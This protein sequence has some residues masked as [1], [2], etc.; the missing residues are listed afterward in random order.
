MA[1]LQY[2]GARYV[3][4]LFDN[5][6]DHSITW[7]AGVSY[8][9]LTIVL[10]NEDTYTSRKPIPPSIGNPADN[11]IYWAMTSNFNAALVALQN[12]VTEINN[13]L[14]AQP[15]IS[16][17]DFGA[18]GDGVTNDYEAIKSAIDHCN[19]SGQTLYFPK[20]EY[21]YK[22][23]AK[24]TVLCNIDFGDST[25]LLENDVDDDIFAIGTPTS[26]YAFDETVVTADY[27]T[28]NNLKGKGFLLRTPV[29]IGLRYGSG[30]EAYYDRYLIVDE[31]GRI[32]NGKLECQIVAGTY[33]AFNPRDLRDDPISISNLRAKTV[34]GTTNALVLFSVYQNNVTIENIEIDY[35]NVNNTTSMYGI[36][37]A[38]YVTGCTFK[39]ITAVNPYGPNNSG[40][41]LEMSGCY[42]IAID[43]FIGT[44]KLGRSWGA[45]GTSDS[46]NCVYS[47]CV[48]Q[49]IDVHRMGTFTANNCV[50]EHANFAGGHGNIIFNNCLFDHDSSHD[51]YD[52]IIKFRTDYMYLL[53]GNL[54]FND[55]IARSASNLSVF[56]DIEMPRVSVAD[57]AQVGYKGLNVSVNNCDIDT[58]I[59]YQLDLKTDDYANPIKFAANNCK[60]SMAMTTRSW[61][62]DKKCKTID[63]NNCELTHDGGE[64]DISA[65]FVFDYANLVNCKVPESIIATKP[66]DATNTITLSV[67]NCLLY[68]A[69]VYSK[70]TI[71]LIDNMINRDINCTVNGSPTNDIRKNNYIVASTN[72]YQSSWNN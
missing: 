54:I 61:S 28:D 23:D 36:I 49:R 22:P 69:S 2:I 71:R 37:G 53:S 39:N 64:I 63:F 9:P 56:L 55:C 44:D 41:V 42:N 3:P 1:N 46:E 48:T 4:K 24:V 32:A 72:T 5:P 25:L 15:I 29:S 17:K 16:V 6:D 57:I 38:N 34:L 13:K 52:G 7:K 59:M 31:D 33:R 50:L 11:P 35:T 65:A 8:E 18:V 47:N 27:I 43:R 21:Y 60:L 66:A 51:N 10:Y 12:N 58:Y 67:V 19:L 68:G 14:S 70:N 45:I 40:Y 30:A 26:V 20:S 62:G